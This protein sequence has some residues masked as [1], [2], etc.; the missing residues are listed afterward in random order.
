ML[1]KMKIMPPNDCF[2]NRGP[3]GGLA[4][5]RRSGTTNT[6]IS[7]SHP[8]LDGTAGDDAEGEGINKWQRKDS[9]KMVVAEGTVPVGG[10]PHKSVREE[11]FTMALTLG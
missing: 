8:I 2:G 5:V 6:P 3:W 1:A 11:L 9:D 4:K 10:L 7:N